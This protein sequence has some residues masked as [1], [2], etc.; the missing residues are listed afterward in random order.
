MRVNPFTAAFAEVGQFFRRSTTDK[1]QASRDFSIPGIIEDR[2][3]LSDRAVQKLSDIDSERVG[4]EKIAASS[5][6]FIESRVP[7][8]EL[9]DGAASALQVHSDLEFLRKQKTRDPIVQNLSLKSPFIDKQIQSFLKIS[10]KLSNLKKAIENTSRAQNFNIKS[11]ESLDPDILT[12]TT[13]HRSS[14]NTFEIKISQLADTHQFV[15]D[16]VSDPFASLEVSGTI[17]IN[18]FEINIETSD[19]LDDIKN[20]I[21]FGEDFNKNGVLDFGEDLN[22]NGQ[23]EVFQVSSNPF[24]KGIYINEDLNGDNVIQGSEDLDGDELLDGGSKENGVVASIKDNRLYLNALTNFSETIDLQ[25]DNDI[26]FNLGFFESDSADN[27]VVKEQQLDS[28]TYENLNT[29]FKSSLFTVAGNSFGNDTNDISGVIPNTTLHLKDVSSDSVSL[30]IST[31]LTETLKNIKNFVAT[32]NDTINF[33]NKELVFSRMLEENVATQKIRNGLNG[34]VM[35]DVLNADKRFNNL[36]KIGISGQNKSKNT[37]SSV[38]IKN[39]AKSFKREISNAALSPPKGSNS[40]FSGLEKIGIR[41]LEDDALVID[42]RKLKKVLEK[43]AGKIINLFTDASNGISKKLDDLINILN[44]P[45]SGTVA[46]QVASKNIS[47]NDRSFDA[48][49]VSSTAK[50]QAAQ[51]DQS[52][53]EKVLFSVTI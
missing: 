28:D 4:N 18:G 50:V 12:A 26:L 5:Y 49:F 2:V 53:K 42:E 37:F 31:D 11:A 17:L 40:I 44:R 51:F 14:V 6:Y 43:N 24:A 21:N 3:S 32:Y 34:K 19:S 22:S 30:S 29:L 23:L 1:N 8:I 47:L 36:E 41:T 35:D 48:D 52:N 33:L 7:K 13:T 25:D 20:K 46:F 45:S 10:E 15:S 38:A 39:L 27:H 9:L 16:T